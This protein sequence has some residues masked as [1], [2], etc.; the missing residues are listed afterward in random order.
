MLLRVKRGK[1]S[2]L[3]ATLS[4]FHIHTVNGF[5]RVD[6]VVFGADLALLLLFAALVAGVGLR[7]AFTYPTGYRVTGAQ[8]VGF[9]LG[10]GDVDVV[11]A[12]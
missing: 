3:G 7:R 1:L 6:G 11:G 2:E 8:S 9:N 5:H 4:R 10:A 12:R